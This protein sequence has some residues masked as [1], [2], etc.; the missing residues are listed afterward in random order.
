M[1]EGRLHSEIPRIQNDG[2][3]DEAWKVRKPCSLGVWWHRGLNGGCTSA[4]LVLASVLGDTLVLRGQSG[5]MES[6]RLSL[7]R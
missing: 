6:E 2:P 1:L 5:K 7:M 3:A 4:G